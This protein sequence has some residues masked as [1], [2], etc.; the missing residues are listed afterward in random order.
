MG[1]TPGSPQLKENS[2]IL[3]D[4]LK[5]SKIVF[6]NREEAEKILSFRNISYKDD[7]KDVLSKMKT[8]GMEVLSITDGLS[9]AYALDN[10]EN[11]YFIKSFGEGAAERTGAGDASLLLLLLFVP[12]F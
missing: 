2:G 7:I 5:N 4:S 12:L 6:I 10:N 1:F 3:I 8:L 9:G 11:F